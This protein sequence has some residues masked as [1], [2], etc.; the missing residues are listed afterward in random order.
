MAAAVAVAGA[1]A[2]SPPK[3]APPLPVVAPE[4]TGMLAYRL[5]RIDAAVGEAIGR[6][7]LPGA[8]ILVGRHGKVVFRRAYGQRAVEP[9]AEPMTTDTVFDLASLTKVVATATSVMTLVERGAVRLQDPVVKYLPDFG[10]E[11]GRE[12]VTVEQLLTHR[13]GLAPDDPMGLYTGTP[14]EIFRRKYATAL[15]Q[16]PGSR[17]VYSD[18]GYEVLGEVVRVVSKRS[19]DRYAAEEVF[20]P[21]GMTETGFRPLGSQQ[22]VPVSRVAPTEKVDGRILR[23]EVHDPRARALGGVAGHAGLFSTADDLARYCSAILGGGKLVLSPVGI[24]EMTRP[25]FFGDGDLRAL[26]WDVETSYSS[27]R[28]DLFPRGSFGHTGWT[29][30]SLWLDPSTDTFVVFLSNRVHPDGSGNVVPLRGVIAT[31]VASAVLDADPAKLRDASEATTLL[32]AIGARAARPA[33]TVAS[34]AAMPL[35][36]AG[37]PVL[38]GIDVLE[39]DDFKAIAGM[40]VAL[41]TNPTGRSADG[42][43]TA[44]VLLSEQA[45]KAGVSL[46]R[47]FSPE[48]GPDG[49]RDEKVPDQTDPGTGL[50]VRS[51]YGESGE[52]RRPSPADLAGLD[53]VV[54]DLQDAGVRFYTYLT[55]LGYVMEEA[56]K[57]NVKVVVLDRPDPIRADVVEGPPADGDRLSFTAYH[58]IPVRTGMTIGELARMFNAERSIGAALTVVK[59]KGYRRSLWFDE[60]GLEWVNPSPNLRSVTQAALY[61][62][63]ALL[64]MTN[65]SVGRGTDAPFEIVGAP[66]VDGAKLASVLSGRGIRGARFA[67]VR[68]TPSSSKHAGAECGGVRITVV[69]RDAL[70]PVTLGLEIAT[71]LRDL[72]PKEWDRSRFGELLRHSASLARFERGESA[73]TIVSGWTA[74]LMEFERRRAA[75]LLYE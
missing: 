48:H 21:L 49:T 9:E 45:R 65:V 19:L 37:T 10:R 68:F 15:A 14:A 51:L 50:P 62:G 36:A 55:T 74:A 35:P 52:S 70:A 20:A 72:F 59:M 6:K 27:N 17:F 75:F 42:R 40:K 60:T 18:A 30:T 38:A 73:P 58:T 2:A 26:G 43:S 24:A 8:V 71:A 54:V 53:A 63:V 11:G 32:S 56:A 46:V 41:L 4:S 1:L 25:R 64:E 66:W 31:I 16:A 22:P 7:Q 33:P 3:T 44:A 13:A 5:D 29:G 61:P 12:K 67:P 28:G 39:A 34:P 69:D 57:A 47:L 23:G